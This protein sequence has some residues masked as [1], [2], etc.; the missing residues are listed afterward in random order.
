M[1]ISKKSNIVTVFYVFWAFLLVMFCNPAI[2]YAAE[3]QTTLQE[4]L[5]QTYLNN[6]DLRSVRIKLKVIE[7]GLTQAYGKYHPYV[8]SNIGVTT[9]SNQGS[10]FGDSA[11]NGSTSKDLG[12][13][14]EQP[15]YR[16]GRTKAAID[17]ARHAI[18]AATARLNEQEQGLLLKTITVYADVLRN[19]HV[20]VLRQQYMQSIEKELEAAQLRFDVGE[21]TKTDV[22]LAHARLAR[23][24]ADLTTAMGALETSYAVYE[25]VIG[26]K[27][28]KLGS[29]VINID[30]PGDLETAKIRALDRHP[31][32]IEAQEN[33]ASAESDINEVF[34]ELLPEVNLSGLWSRTY[35]PQPGII[36]Q[37]TSRSIGIQATIPLYMGGSTRSRVRAARYTAQDYEIQMESVKREVMQNLISEWATWMSA[38]NEIR[39]RESQAQAALTALEGVK[40]EQELGMRSTLDVLTTNQDAI[41][42]REAVLTAQR[43]EI[44]A[45]F[46]VLAATGLLTH[47]HL[48][49]QNVDEP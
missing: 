35:D 37:Q 30:F 6:P 16:G 29:P 5:L 7:E 14:F 1:R 45:R 22:A 23:A 21:N 4:A 12:V 38:K 33:F 3:G 44:V 20:V 31:T 28:L 43:N 36:N 34:G 17:S 13:S 9:T 26:K 25:E 11:S 19:Q 47:T 49:L 24:E 10:N 32:I 40:L 15:L 18:K 27:S 8:A 2:L 39:A 42:A 48:G 46:S 41:A